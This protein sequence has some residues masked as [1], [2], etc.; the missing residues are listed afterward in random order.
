MTGFVTT[1][2]YARCVDMPLCLA[3]T[4]LRAGKVIT[5][6]RI[7]LTLGQRLELRMLALSQLA[8]L[9][10][11]TDPLYLNAAL[12]MCSAG[13]YNNTMITSPLGYTYSSG[14]TTTSNPY[15]VC[16]IESPG[17]YDVLV[18]NNT[19]NLDL[20]VAVAGVLKLYF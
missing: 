6:A 10:P 13:L 7:V 2:R 16:V 19:S 1:N 9:T 4:E 12:G 14:G 20:S 3:Q 18:S 15:D 5:L 11:G 8:V 17:T